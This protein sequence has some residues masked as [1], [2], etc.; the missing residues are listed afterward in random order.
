MAG[1]PAGESKEFTFKMTLGCALAMLGFIGY[2][3]VK[4][5]T[6]R[7]QQA[8]AAAAAMEADEESQPLKVLASPKV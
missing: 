8:K 3:H 2:S 1:A 5:V 4:I 6:Y 7:L